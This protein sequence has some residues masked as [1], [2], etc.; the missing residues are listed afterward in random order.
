LP[1][2]RSWRIRLK[3]LR[4]HAGSIRG[5]ILRIVRFVFVKSIKA[6]PCRAGYAADA[7]TF[8]CTAPSP[9][10]S[11]ACGTHCCT[12]HGTQRSVLE[13]FFSLAVYLLIRIVVA[14]L[15]DR[16]RRVCRLGWISCLV[17]WGRRNSRSISAG[18]WRAGRLLAL[19][20]GSLLNRRGLL[21]CRSDLRLTDLCR[22]RSGRLV[23]GV[24]PHNERC[25]DSSGS[26]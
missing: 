20:R 8:P 23:F 15:H 5:L 2:S 1:P 13:Y 14:C 26:H 9:C 25:C 17:G 19:H 6:S 7:R 3:A 12:Y 11:A 21:L 24:S 10:D 4:A 22:L 18:V 16:L